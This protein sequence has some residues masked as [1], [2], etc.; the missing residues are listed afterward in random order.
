[1]PTRSRREALADALIE[2]REAGAREGSADAAELATRR[3]APVRA[4][5][6]PTRA[7]A[8]ARAIAEMFADRDLTT[9]EEF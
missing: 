3:H 4:T 7:T 8:F 6:L 1:M 9:R 5:A 2:A